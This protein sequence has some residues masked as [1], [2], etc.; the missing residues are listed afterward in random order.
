MKTGANYNFTEGK[1]CSKLMKIQEFENT[2][3]MV[4]CSMIAAVR[5]EKAITSDSTALLI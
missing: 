5:T 1:L 4:Q 3:D 2:I